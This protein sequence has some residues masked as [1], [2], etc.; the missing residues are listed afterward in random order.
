MSRSIDSCYKW[1]CHI[2]EFAGFSSP[3]HLQ[4]PALSGDVLPPSTLLFDPQ[5]G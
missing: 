3:N 5:G 4:F 1:T 2:F